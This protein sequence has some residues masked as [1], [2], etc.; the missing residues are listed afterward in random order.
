MFDY[1]GLYKFF[2]SFAI[3]LD[4]VYLLPQIYIIHQNVA[5]NGTVGMLTAHYL[6][7]CGL[8]KFL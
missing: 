5:E 8:N 1:Q 2:K 6:F 3:I 7:M 4:S